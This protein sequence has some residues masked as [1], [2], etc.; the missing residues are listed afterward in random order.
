MR[1]MKNTQEKVH[2][3]PFEK[4]KHLKCTQEKNIRFLFVQVWLWTE[5]FDS[6]SKNLEDA[7][8]NQMI[9]TV[10]YWSCVLMGWIGYNEWIGWILW[11]GWNMVIGGIGYIR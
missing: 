2:A 8:V 11:I 4:K 1:H 10:G 9:D 6:D 5:Y 3:M 7:K